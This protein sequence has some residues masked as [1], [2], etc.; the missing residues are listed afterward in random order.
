MIDF[1][2]FFHRKQTYYIIIHI[3]ILLFLFLIDL[4]K[5]FRY[6]KKINRIAYIV[7]EK[8]IVNILVFFQ[9]AINTEYVINPPTTNNKKESF[10][11]NPLSL[12][13][14]F[15]LYIFIIYFCF[16]NK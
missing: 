1:K 9:F 8:C 4:I 12:T 11:F 7:K 3:F 5:I 15:Y 6:L 16:F 2:Y 14:S 10:N 13:F